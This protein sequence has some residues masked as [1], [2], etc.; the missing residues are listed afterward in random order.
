[1]LLLSLRDNTF[2]NA[3]PHLPGRAGRFSG[4]CRKNAAGRDGGLHLVKANTLS[5]SFDLQKVLIR[6]IYVFMPTC[7]VKINKTPFASV[8]ADSDTQGSVN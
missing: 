3:L 5:R 7:K 1:M 2:L 4:T 8:D 6:T